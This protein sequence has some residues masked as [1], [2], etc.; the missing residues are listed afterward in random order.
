MVFFFLY[1][2]QKYYKMEIW[3]YGSLAY[4]H[5]KSTKLAYLICSSICSFSNFQV[6]IQI[7]QQ[8]ILDKEDKVYDLTKL[9]VG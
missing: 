9:K 1:R 5:K 8:T 6:E 4:L 7:N 2:S 3:V